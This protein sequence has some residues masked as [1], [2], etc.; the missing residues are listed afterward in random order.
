MRNL[1]VKVNYKVTQTVFFQFI[2]PEKA[3]LPEMTPAFDDRGHFPPVRVSAHGQFLGMAD[4]GTA[5]NA[6]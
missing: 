2:K 4:S 5:D 6:D 1:R 3:F